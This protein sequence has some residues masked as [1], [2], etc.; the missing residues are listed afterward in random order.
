MAQPEQE[1]LKEHGDTMDGAAE[2]LQTHGAAAAGSRN[3]HTADAIPMPENGGHERS[4]AAHLGKVHEQTRAADKLKEGMSANTLR[5]PP[6]VVQRVG[7]QH[8]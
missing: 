1:S 4:H 2:A 7:K 3:G 6:T 8:R 5:E